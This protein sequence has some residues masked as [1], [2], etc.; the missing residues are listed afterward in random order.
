MQHTL[1]G[2]TG[3][4][5]LLVGHKSQIAGVSGATFLFF[6]LNKTFHFGENFTSLVISW[7]VSRA[8][9][10]ILHPFISHHM[11]NLKH[12]HNNV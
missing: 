4:V 12:D 1:A 3:Q 10:R 6:Y 8:D 2:T 11:P 9:L 5:R 7:V